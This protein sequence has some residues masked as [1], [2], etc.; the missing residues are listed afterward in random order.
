M[1]D[2][3]QIWRIQKLDQIFSQALLYLVYDHDEFMLDNNSVK[4]QRSIGFWRYVISEIWLF[5]LFL[6]IVAT[7]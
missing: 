7:V 2:I 1:P 5:L 4:I 3:N 6:A